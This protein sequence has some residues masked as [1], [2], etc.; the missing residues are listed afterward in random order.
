MFEILDRILH[1][2]D[3]STFG[4]A[5]WRFGLAFCDRQCGDRKCLAFLHI[6]QGN[7]GECGLFFVL[8]FAVSIARLINF[9]PAG[10]FD[11]IAF[12]AKAFFADGAADGSLFILT[13][14]GENCKETAYD[15]IINLTFF[16]AH[17]IQLYKLFCWN[18]G[19]VIGYPA[20]IDE[21]FACLEFLHGKPSGKL[22]VRSHSAGF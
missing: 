13:G 10:R 7:L 11:K 16:I 2:G 21:R 20:V 12:R 3:Q 18:D 19:M 6:R 17:M 5:G 9:S 15:Q 4:E 1:G 8:V 14:R 22:A